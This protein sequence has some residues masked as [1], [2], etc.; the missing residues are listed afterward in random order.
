MA[1]KKRGPRQDKRSRFDKVRDRDAV[2]RLKSRGYADEEVAENLNATGNRSYPVDAAMVRRDWQSAM[3]VWERDAAFNVGAMRMREHQR[4]LDLE[5]EFAEHY[6]NHPTHAAPGL[7]GQLDTI[8]TRIALLGLNAP[9]QSKVDVEG[10]LEVQLTWGDLPPV[11]KAAS[12]SKLA[13]E[14]GDSL[15]AADA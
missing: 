7:N 15:E 6:E 4:L 14:A 12:G 9:P 3:R 11:K 13:L 2:V 5:R 10:S 1:E 8:K